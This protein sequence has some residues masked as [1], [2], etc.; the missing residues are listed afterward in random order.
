MKTCR[1]HN[2]STYIC[3]LIEHAAYNDLIT[4]FV[5]QDRHVQYHN[6]PLDFNKDQ[7]TYYQSIHLHLLCKLRRLPKMA[8]SPKE[9]VRL[10]YHQQCNQTK[11]DAIITQT[12]PTT[13]TYSS[14]QSCSDGLAATVQ[15]TNSVLTNLHFMAAI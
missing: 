10:G 15:P 6:Q 9:I 5:S 14:I 1:S 3:C 4:P 2:F 11:V 7:H 13:T 8:S 12:Y